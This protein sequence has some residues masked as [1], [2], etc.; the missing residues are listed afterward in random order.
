[1]QAGHNAKYMY[2]RMCLSLIVRSITMYNIDE[3]LAR[4]ITQLQVK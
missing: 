1:M 4:S 3:R 2:A